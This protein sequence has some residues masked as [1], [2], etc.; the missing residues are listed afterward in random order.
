MLK[1]MTFSDGRP[2]IGLLPGSR[3]EEI[4]KLL[5]LMIKSVEIVSKHFPKLQCILPVAPT[6]SDAQVQSYIE[7][8]LVDIK[9]IR[10]DIYGSLSVCDLVFV[11]SGTATLETA[12]INVPMVIV[13][14]VSLFTYWIGRI[15]VKVPHIGLVNLVAGDRVVPELIQKDANPQRLADE[16]LLILNDDISRV[17]MTER[18]KEVKNALGIGGA[19]KRTAEIAIEMMKT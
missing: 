4:N 13:Y 10:N 18:L 8:S 2:V 3:G 15:V 9:L 5:P 17:E 12:M 11:A 16:A 19:S 6:I 1:D 14:K 7:N